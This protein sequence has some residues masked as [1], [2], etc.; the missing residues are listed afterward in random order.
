VRAVIYENY[1]PPEVLQLTDLA[2]PE[3]KDEEILVRVRATTVTAGDWRMRKAEPVTARL[4]NGLFRPKRVAV[5]GFE[6]S[7]DVAAV[8]SGVTRFAV[9]DQIFGY[10]GFR[11]GAYAEYL[12]VPQTGVVAIKPDTMT[13]GEAAAVPIGAL[14]ALKLLG[15]AG[16][17]SGKQVLV[18]G[19]SGS[20][21]TYAVQIAKQFGATVTGVCSTDNLEWVR[22]L[23]AD[24]MI[25][26]TQEDFT[27]G[28]DRFDVIFDAVGKI[29]RR[30]R[31]TALSSGGIYVNVGDNRKDRAEDLDALRGIIEAGHLRAVIDRTYPLEEIVEA[32]RYVEDGHKKGN[33][34][35]RVM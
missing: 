18:Y 12:C 14:A 19:A 4:Y 22:A 27:E 33:V 26:Y 5:L 35:I 30:K 9:G 16:V 6:F 21:G 20:V 31:K 15:R 3:P 1:G 32:H 28:H 2:Q 29:P 11:F 8:G 34:V 13:Y 24:A 25:D 7:G 23:G 10:N 17:S